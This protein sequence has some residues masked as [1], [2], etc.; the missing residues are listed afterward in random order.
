MDSDA[1]VM[2]GN[3]IE[4]LGG[5]SFRTV[6][7]VQRYSLLDQYAMGLV[8]DSAVAP[9]FYVENPTNMSSNRTRESAPEVGI[10]FN[11][12]RRDVLIQDV[13]A[14]LGAR[15]P[16]SSD[17]ARVHRQAFVYVVSA[18]KTADSGQVSK[19]DGIRRAWE[20]FFFQATDRR[21]QAITT[22]R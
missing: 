21:M 22:L 1:S 14:V 8:P 17:S 12:T 19:V 4:D 18:G 6:A 5:G 7:S 10:T 15:S 3:D 2:E 13:V 9:F 20:S 16:S 11:G